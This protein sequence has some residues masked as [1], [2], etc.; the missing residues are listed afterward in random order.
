MGMDDIEEEDI[1]MAP[2]LI[3]LEQLKDQDLCPMHLLGV[4]NS[5]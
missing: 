3:A 4:N 2:K 5:K 1:P